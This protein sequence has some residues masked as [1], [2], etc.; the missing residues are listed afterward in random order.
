[1]SP[2]EIIQCV[3]AL[4][5]ASEQAIAWMSPGGYCCGAERVNGFCSNPAC[6]RRAIWAAGL[7]STF[8]AHHALRLLRINQRKPKS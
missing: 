1:M 4:D 6:T 2:K 3:R 5:A 7:H 8:A